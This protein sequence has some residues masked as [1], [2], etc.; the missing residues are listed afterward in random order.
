MVYFEIC[1]KVLFDNLCKRFYLS[2]KRKKI[3]FQAEYKLSTNQLLK[4][5][6]L[7]KE[8]KPTKNIPDFLRQWG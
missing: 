1:L 8:N 7:E 3:A 4:A 5:T 6:W 2:W